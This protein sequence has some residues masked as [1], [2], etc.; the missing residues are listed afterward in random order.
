M[1]GCYRCGA[2]DHRARH[3][4]TAIAAAAAAKERCFNCGSTGHQAA[5]CTIERGNTACY[6][7]GEEGHQAR[8]CTSVKEDAP[9]VDDAKVNKLVAKRAELRASGDYAGADALR[10]QLLA[11]GVRLQDSEGTWTTASRR[12][13]PPRVCFAF[14]RG[15][16]SHGQKCHFKHVIAQA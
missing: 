6:I 16:C 10:A 3:C 13:R 9:Q 2:D 5:D 14:Q 4:P 12:K 7:C 8:Y 11:M 15:E 1:T